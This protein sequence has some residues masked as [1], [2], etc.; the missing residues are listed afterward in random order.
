MPPKFPWFP[1]YVSDWLG[2][3]RI[4]AMTAAQEGAYH[5][6][7]CLAWSDKECS[8]P[9]DRDALAS[10]SK[11]PVEQLDTVLAC[12]EP[13]PTIKKRIHN[14][15]LTEEWKKAEQYHQVRSNS[16]AIG[17]LKRWHGSAI[18]PPIAK[19]Q[20]G[21]SLLQSQSHPQKERKNLKSAVPAK[22]ADRTTRGFE[23]TGEGLKDTILNMIPKDLPS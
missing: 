12:F 10:M 11:L 8:L 17:A 2:S 16:G 9:S 22:G 18:A 20:L 4:A 3:T 5:R 7:L 13:H 23:L 15:R 6:L 21:N 1:C 14:A 19:P